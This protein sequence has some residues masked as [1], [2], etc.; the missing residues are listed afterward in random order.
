MIAAVMYIINVI[1]IFWIIILLIATLIGTQSYDIFNLII[2]LILTFLNLI[3]L[4]KVNMENSKLELNYF[5]LI[6]KCSKFI[7]NEEFEEIYH[8]LRKLRKTKWYKDIDREFSI[9]LRKN[10]NQF[11]DIDEFKIDYLEK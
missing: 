4:K 2:F 1:T 7:K 8:Y 3:S 9:D 6:K 10:L 5:N 11:Y